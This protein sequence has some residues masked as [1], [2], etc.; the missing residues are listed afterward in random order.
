MSL[1]C[2][3]FFTRFAE[4]NT[5]AYIA[6]AIAGRDVGNPAASAFIHLQLWG[7]LFLKNL[8]LS[9]LF[10][11]FSASSAGRTQQQNALP[12]RHARRCCVTQ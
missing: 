7:R 5:A 6:L 9:K 8:S 12:G 2:L 11:F 10:S 1:F 4:R 3:L